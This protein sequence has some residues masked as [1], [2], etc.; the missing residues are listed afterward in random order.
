MAGKSRAGVLKVISIYCLIVELFNCLIVESLICW[1]VE[2]KV[3]Q[4]TKDL[5][6]L[7]ETM[8]LQNSKK[9]CENLRQKIC[10]ISGKSLL[11]F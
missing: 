3:C 6:V 2:I 11:N 1:I 9:I 8:R 4:G 5:A 7:V 10:V